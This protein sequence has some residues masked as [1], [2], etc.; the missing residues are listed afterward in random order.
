MDNNHPWINNHVKD[1]V[2]PH[3]SLLI[4]ILRGDEMIVPNGD[5]LILEGGYNNS[6]RDRVTETETTIFSSQRP[7]RRKPQ[8]V[9]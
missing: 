7:D 2:V 6:Q 3:G 5:T 1:I 4:M 8:L 9:Q